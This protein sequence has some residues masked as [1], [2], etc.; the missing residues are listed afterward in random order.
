[1]RRLC[2]VFSG[3]LLL[4]ACAG[5]QTYLYV[6][7]KTAEGRQCIENCAIEKENCLLAEDS[8]LAECEKRYAFDQRLYGDCTH[9]NGSG[10][11]PGCIRPQYCAP[12]NT[13]KCTNDFNA[14]YANCG[15]DV[16]P[17]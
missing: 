6:P 3:L 17:E 8:K 1:M 16:V 15:G 7:P 2:F 11:H 13:I 5:E 12:P 9:A 10:L 4:T 14:C